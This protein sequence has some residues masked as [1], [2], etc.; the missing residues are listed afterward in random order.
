[1]NTKINLC[2]ECALFFATCAS[3]NVKFGNGKGNDNVISCDSTQLCETELT[4]NKP[5]KNLNSSHPSSP[6][7]IACDSNGNTYDSEY[8]GINGLTKREDCAMRNLQGILANPEFHRE[9]DAQTMV[10]FA[11]EM[12]D[13]LFERLE[14]RKT[15]STK[16]T[17]AT[18][19]TSFYSCACFR[20]FS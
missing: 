15:Q 19:Q 4:S 12:A 3:K 6:S 16:T 1:M 20:R 10:D 2:D 5:L 13:L 14:K 9:E 11:V 8:T 18:S 7:A 17:R